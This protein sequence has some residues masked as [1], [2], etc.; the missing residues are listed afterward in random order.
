MHHFKELKV[1]Q[2]S[3]DLVT[4]LYIRLKDLPKDEKYG[5]SSQMKRSANSVPSNIA[6]GAGR[7]SQKEFK[8]FLSVAK[9]SLNELQTQLIVSQKLNFITQEDLNTLEEMIIEIGKMISGL[10]KSLN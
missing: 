10:S 5:L 2:K 4:E 3:I 1:W 7:N 9:G 6:E 8:Y